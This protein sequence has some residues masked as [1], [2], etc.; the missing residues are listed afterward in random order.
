MCA[1][2]SSRA[3]R[4]IAARDPEKAAA[5]VR[6]RSAAES[7]TKKAQKGDQRFNGTREGQKGPIEMRLN[8]FGPVL[9]LAIGAF[10]EWGQNLLAL[11]DLL[12]CERAQPWDAEGFKSEN[13]AKS[14]Y[15]SG[16]RTRIGIAATRAVI[17][18]IVGK[19][20]VVVASNLQAE[21]RAGRM[22]DEMETQALERGCLEG[23][24]QVRAR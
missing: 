9:G 24:L 13:H 16:I 8:S 20:N 3:G 12:A 4:G 1:L 7:Y 15:K 11:V 18:N 23:R 22:R 6:E 14:Y 5:T 2:F 19:R 21:G 17:S 10:A